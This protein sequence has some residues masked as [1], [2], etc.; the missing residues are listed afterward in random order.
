M[1]DLRQ[2]LVK[3]PSG[4]GMAGRVTDSLPIEPLPTHLQVEILYLSCYEYLCYE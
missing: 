2:V 4:T 3:L 1:I